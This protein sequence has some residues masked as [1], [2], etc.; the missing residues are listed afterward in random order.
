MS[1]PE[2]CPPSG[3][4]PNRGTLDVGSDEVCNAPVCNPAGNATD[5][6][7]KPWWDNGWVLFPPLN[8]TDSDVLW[9]NRR[10]LGRPA[11]SSLLKSIDYRIKEWP[12]RFG[13][14]NHQYRENACLMAM[15]EFEQ[16]S[17]FCRC[18]T[19]GSTKGRYKSGRCGVWK[20]CPYC[21]HKKRKV[22]LSKFLPVFRRGNWWFLTISP[23]EM[24][25]LY[26]TAQR[27]I[28]WWE[29]CRFTLDTLRK[30]GLIKGAFLLETISIHAYWP[31]PRALPH[32]HV[33]LLADSI[34]KPTT[35]ELK[36]VF[37]TYHGQWWHP[38]QRC[39]MEPDMPTPIWSVAST[40]TYSIRQQFDFAS[41]LSYLC[42]PVNLATAYINDWPRVAGTRRDAIKFNENVIEAI[43]AWCEALRHRWG[44]RY[45]AALQ[46]AH[47][48]F[49]GI[50]KSK[51][52]TKSFQRLVKDLLE[53]CSLTRL[54]QFDPDD[55]G[56]PVELDDDAPA[57]Q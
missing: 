11:V 49:T 29:A 5:V 19:I 50:E 12:Q 52:E 23:T 44:H 18:G 53:E 39:W 46:H 41:V 8:Y 37:A 47:G 14:E 36:Q 22:I 3:T 27:L 35:D 2:S 21:S 51:R 38:K 4:P 56:V 26:V 6:L 16:A 42:N 43:N 20:V 55:L 24:C 1:A 25:N 54:M 32:V 7:E 17:E 40:R 57:D 30:S 33:V 48:D 28:D 34:T 15:S 9:S 45:M 13:R 31:V 10:W